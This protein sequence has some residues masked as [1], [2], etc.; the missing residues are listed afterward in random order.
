MRIIPTAVRA[1]LTTAILILVCAWT[2]LA[3]RVT[4]PSAQIEFIA[5]PQIKVGSEPI[6]AYYDEITMKRGKYWAEQFLSLTT[7][8]NESNQYD[9]PYCLYIL[10]YRTGDVTYR[11][12]ARKVA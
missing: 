4:F 8:L 11:D 12:Y 5:G 10:Y 1:T 9:L 7:I 6:A 2:T 3:Q